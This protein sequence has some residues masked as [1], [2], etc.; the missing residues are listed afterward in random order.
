[1][2]LISACVKPIDWQPKET[3]GQ[4]PVP[5]SRLA[6]GSNFTSVLARL[7]LSLLS[8]TL[9]FMVFLTRLLPL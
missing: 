1:M 8:L 3:D 5:K 7:L 4:T 9:F 2:D 6:L